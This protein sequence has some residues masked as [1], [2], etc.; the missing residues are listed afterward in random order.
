MMKVESRRMAMSV[1]TRFDLPSQVRAQPGG[2]V[3][4]GRVFN[5]A[6]SSERIGAFGTSPHTNRGQEALSCFGSLVTLAATL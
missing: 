4:H 5:P 3:Q 6:Y 1:A 2:L